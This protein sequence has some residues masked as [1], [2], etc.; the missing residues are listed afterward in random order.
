MTRAGKSYRSSTPKEPKEPKREKLKRL[1]NYRVAKA[2]A[3]RFVIPGIIAVVASIA[4][5]FVAMYGF[6]GTKLERRVRPKDM[7][8]NPDSLGDVLNKDKLTQQILAA[9]NQA[10]DVFGEKPDGVDVEPEEKK[11]EPE[12]KKIEP[13]EKEEQKEKEKA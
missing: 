11:I 10:S 2:Q 5:L 1:E 4:F 9:M 8:V 13:E 12:E 7:L 6:K 3:R